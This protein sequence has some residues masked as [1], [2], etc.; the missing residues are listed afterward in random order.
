MNYI[1]FF[2]RRRAEA[3]EKAQAADDDYVMPWHNSPPAARRAPN[4]SASPISPASD[5]CFA[6]QGHFRTPTISL[7]GRLAAR[8]MGAPPYFGAR[9]RQRLISHAKMMTTGEA[10]AGGR[11]EI[12]RRY[13]EA[14]S[15]H[16]MYRCTPG[17]P[18]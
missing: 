2:Q 7:T 10:S 6:F 3:R 18:L 15:R 16:K 11:G 1:Y 13:A 12:S 4:S 17:A 9:C 14:E 8:R 5:I